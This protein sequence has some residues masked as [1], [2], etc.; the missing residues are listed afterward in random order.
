MPIRILREWWKWHKNWDEL[1]NCC[2]KC[3]Y[4]RRVTK[5]GT[6]IIDYFHPCENLDPETKLCRIYPDRLTKCSHC[7]KVTLFTALFNKTLPDDCPYVQTFRLWKNRNQ[8]S[9]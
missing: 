5:N 8:Q 6:L 9:G 3:C 2:G 4:E 1:C 7:G